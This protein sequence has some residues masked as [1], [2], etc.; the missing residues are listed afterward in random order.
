MTASDRLRWKGCIVISSPL[1]FFWYQNL[2]CALNRSQFLGYRTNFDAVL[3]KTCRTF[4]Q[5]M[6]SK[7]IFRRLPTTATQFPGCLTA[8]ASVHAPWKRLTKSRKTP[9]NGGFLSDKCA[10]WPHS[11][12]WPPR[13]SI[14]H[15]SRNPGICEHARNRPPVGWSYVRSRPTHTPSIYIWLKLWLVRQIRPRYNSVGLVVLAV[16]GESLFQT[17]NNKEKQRIRYFVFRLNHE[18]EKIKSDSRKL[19]LAPS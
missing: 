7:M 15:T 1:A 6:G 18:W 9:Q 3:S 19:G 4:S 17:L 16:V 5:V 2:G 12:M 13:A 8:H 11:D 10:F 14:V